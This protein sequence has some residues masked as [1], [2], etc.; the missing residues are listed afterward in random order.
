MNHYH[1]R[2]TNSELDWEAFPTREEA[3]TEAERLKRMDESYTIE[4]LNG[5]CQRCNNIKPLT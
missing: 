2:W 5:D 4:E 1:I 3:K